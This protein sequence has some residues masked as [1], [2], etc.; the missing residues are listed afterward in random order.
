MPKL[1]S[2]LLTL[3]LTSALV[4]PAFAQVTELRGPAT[5]TPLVDE[6]LNGIEDAEEAAAAPQVVFDEPLRDAID[7]DETDNLPE[8]ARATPPAPTGALNARARRAQRVGI[9]LATGDTTPLSNTPATPVQGG[10]VTQGDPFAPLGIRRGAFTFFPTVEQSIGYTSNA[11]FASN[12]EGSAFSQTNVNL[13]AV[14]DW[15]RHQ[16]R[17]QI[18]GGYTTFFN[19]ESDDLP[20]V[21]AD[22]QLRLDGGRGLELTF[23]GAYDLR[24]ESAVSDNI[25]APDGFIVDGRPI[26]QRFAGSAEIARRGQLFT[27]SLRLS[28]D[29]LTFGDADVAGGG[30]FSQST[31]DNLLTLATLRLGYEVSPAWRPFVEGEV[32]AR[33]YS[34][35]V[36]LNGDDRDAF[37]YGLRAGAEFGSGEILTGNLAVGYANETFKSANLG[38][39]GGL[40]I[41]GQIDWS[42]RRFTTI[43]ATG[44]TEF[45]GS[46]DAFE[47]GSIIYAG[48][49]GITRDVRPNLSLNALVR[50]SLRDYV[51]TARED[52]SVG[53]EAGFEWRM[54]RSVA[55]F[56]TAGYENVE[57]TDLDASYEA[58]TVRGG[59]RL[60]R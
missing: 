30:T 20:T 43:S 34:E 25:N 46:T 31:R 60:A 27:P 37:R 51:G 45:A 32:G 18:G 49:L 40:T 26:V 44:T 52:Q 41:D 50:A 29:Y 15:S 22:A 16:L 57:S 5:G 1:V 24:T 48:S 58:T 12:G 55:L 13:S 8:A 39:L 2:A 38:D 28:A 53:A 42:P 6:N 9:D 17:G 21:N 23:G 10:G 33:L 14:S 59:L 4:S 19:G 36:D 47:S 11:D 3:A 35:D 7:L 54:N 56:G